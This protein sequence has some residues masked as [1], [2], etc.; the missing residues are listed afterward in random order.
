MRS[1]DG[2]FLVNFLS[3]HGS[4]DAIQFGFRLLVGE[5]VDVGLLHL[6]DY[7]SFV[8]SEWVALC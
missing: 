5:V 7:T 2:K 3:C 6:S 4:D 1:V 8:E